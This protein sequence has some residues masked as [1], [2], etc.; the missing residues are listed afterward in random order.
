MILVSDR[1]LDPFTVSGSVSDVL[2]PEI[3]MKS[4]IEITFSSPIFMDSGTV[5]G[6][7]DPS[8]KD[9]VKKS[10]LDHLTISPS[11]SVTESGISL[12]DPKKIILTGDFQEGKRYHVSLDAIEDIYGRSVKFSLNFTPEKKPLLSLAPESQNSIFP[13]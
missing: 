9:D 2:S 10:I 13:V 4:R 7:S 3:D 8:W 1:K 11:I 6:Q 5:N 12:L